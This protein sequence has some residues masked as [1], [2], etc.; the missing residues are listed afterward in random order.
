MEYVRI[1]K[2]TTEYRFSTMCE[3]YP[4]PEGADPKLRAAVDPQTT[5]PTQG[6]TPRA[7][8]LSSART[9]RCLTPRTARCPAD[10]LDTCRIHAKYIR[11]HKAQ[12]ISIADEMIREYVLEYVRI[13]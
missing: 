13:R 1:R 3:M 6:L 4:N 12:C 10:A 2:D 5:P 8:T 7:Q 9:V 11:I